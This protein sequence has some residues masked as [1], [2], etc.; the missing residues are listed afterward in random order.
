MPSF[1]GLK[2]TDTS[3]LSRSNTRV[4]ISLTTNLGQ[5]TLL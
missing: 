5:I 2:K 1:M 3:P 4:N